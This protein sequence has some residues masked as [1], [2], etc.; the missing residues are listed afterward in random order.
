MALG[1]R[2]IL[3]AVAA[4][5][6]WAP[7][8]SA[9][10]APIPQPAAVPALQPAVGPGTDPGGDSTQRAVDPTGDTRVPV[11][12]TIDG[13]SAAWTLPNYYDQRLSWSLSSC[14][15]S[16]KD[17]VS[18]I[19]LFQD[20]LVTECARLKTPMSWSNLSLG[21][22]TLQV[23][24]TRRLRAA[25]DARATRT[26]MVNPGGPGVAAGEMA[27]YTAYLE[28]EVRALDDIVAV[29]PRGT[30]LSTPLTCTF[31][32]D[33]I[34]DYRTPTAA[35]IAAQQAAWKKTVTA[36]AA[37]SPVMLRNITTN[38]TVRDHDL[39]RALLGV[40]QV[41]FLGIS[42]GT[43]LAS[44]YGQAF[45]SRVGRFVLDSNT[46]FTS[47]WRTS[48]GWQP[49]GFQRRTERQ[50]YAWL[51]RKHARYGLGSSVAV[52]KANIDGIRSAAAKGL[53]E[54]QSPRT[55]DDAI[56]STMYADFQ[57]PDLANVLR[58]WYLAARRTTKP[59][60]VPKPENYRSSEDTVFVAIQCNDSTWSKSPAA[61]VTDG[62]TKGKAYPLLG[63][64]QVASPCAY[65]PFAPSIA[66]V[67]TG[68]AVPPM[69][70]VQNEVDPATPWEGASLAERASANTRMLVV[71][72]AGAHGAYLGENSCVEQNVTAY[73]TTGALPAGSVCAGLPLPDETVVYPVSVHHTGTPVAR[74]TKWAPV[75]TT[76]ATT[77]RKK[78]AQLHTPR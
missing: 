53:V 78:I 44:H 62:L 35:E 26:L 46:Q 32:A 4:A 7:T 2:R 51:A 48:F 75:R 66:P 23:T 27:P 40:E 47:T 20:G 22:I 31:Y 57:F 19:E 52:V 30:G 37:Q 43:W 36:C 73:L 8:A 59:T 10:A 9:L 67:P 74:S 28:P 41:D 39:V 54:G 63:Y 56:L 49:K 29:D 25:G 38:N 72:D 1:S 24:R 12:R 50:F 34:T 68:A 58:E 42:A 60:A 6:V 21:S 13:K 64:D 5:L 45:P 69:L 70:M 61:Y 77:I 11:G 71:D 15:S 18:L 55:I 33:G 14:S 16:V 76:L 17:I 65:W 3:A